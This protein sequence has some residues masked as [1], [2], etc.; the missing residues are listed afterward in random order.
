MEPTKEPVQ[1]QET[2]LTLDVIIMAGGLSCA[3]GPFLTLLI[4]ENRSPPAGGESPPARGEIWNTV[5]VL[6]VDPEGEVGAP[7]M[8]T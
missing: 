6:L 4:F 8:G 2:S 7:R 5:R 3:D 1:L